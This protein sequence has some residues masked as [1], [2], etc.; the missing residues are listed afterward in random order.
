[1]MNF[2]LLVDDIFIGV[3]NQVKGNNYMPVNVLGY[4]VY[5]DGEKVADTN[6]T[7]Y[8]FRDLSNGTHTASIVQKFDTGNS[9]QLTI[10]FDILTTGIKTIADNVLAIYTNGDELH[11]DGEYTNGV[12]YN[13][14]GAAV[15]NLYGAATNSLSSLPNGI[16]IVKAQ[17]ADGKIMTAKITK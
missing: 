6:D 11:I 9:A 16:Y 7:E 14:S 13:T 1:M 5:L 12:V 15:M 2:L 17:K 10:S 4:E 8:T 3:D